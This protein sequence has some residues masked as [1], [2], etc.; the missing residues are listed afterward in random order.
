MADA[1]WI[2]ELFE[3]MPSGAAARRVLDVRLQAVI[4]RL[5]AALESAADDLIDYAPDAIALTE[6]P[7]AVRTL[8]KQRFRWSYGVLQALYKHRRAALRPG[9]RRV[10]VF[11]LPTILGAHL[12]TPL[13]A[14]AADLGAFIALYLGFGASVIPFAIASLIADL[15]ITAYAMRLDRAPARLAWDWL[16]F[17][18]VY[19]WILFFALARAVVAALRGGAVGWGKLVRKGS[20]RAPSQAST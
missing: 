5:P 19:R 12:L 2:T 1:K 17:R 3:E 8:V 13:L 20:V 4:E 18:A 14:P 16:V 15:S 7:E 11:M 9:S 6:A 10:G